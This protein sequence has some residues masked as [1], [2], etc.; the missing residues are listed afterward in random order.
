MMELTPKKVCF[1]DVPTYHYMHAWQ[2]AFKEAR[3]SNWKIYLM[4]QCRF[5]RRISNVENILAPVLDTKHREHIYS[6]RIMEP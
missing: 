2:F 5:Q 4:D 6:E 3:K 1:N